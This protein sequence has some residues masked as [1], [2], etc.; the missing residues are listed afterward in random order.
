MVPEASRALSIVPERI[1]SGFRRSPAPFGGKRPGAMALRRLPCGA[2][3]TARDF[4]ISPI[5]AFG[6]G[7]GSVKGPPFHTD[8]VRIAPTFAGC[9]ASIQLLP[10]HA[11]P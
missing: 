4:V 7:G 9:R 1:E 6:I 5:P 2:H 3:S 8:V 11:L 10:S